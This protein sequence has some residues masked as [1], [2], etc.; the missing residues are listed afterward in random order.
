MTYP[1]CKR[2][3]E[4]DTKL[5]NIV[6]ESESD[7]IA[8]FLRVRNIDTLDLTDEDLLSIVNMYRS[9]ENKLIPSFTLPTRRSA[10]LV[11]ERKRK[12]DESAEYE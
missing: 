2:S 10:R 4:K 6:T 11:K 1:S 5:E 8:D 7:A 12:R 9:A 3:R